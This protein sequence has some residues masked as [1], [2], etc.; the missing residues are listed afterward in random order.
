[1][2]SKD[3]LNF[4]NH[5]SIFFINLLYLAQKI[6]DFNNNNFSKPFEALELENSMKNSS[7]AL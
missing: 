6:R 4:C 5:Y 2:F 7:F 3:F 1:M